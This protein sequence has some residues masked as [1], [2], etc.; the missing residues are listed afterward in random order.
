MKILIADDHALFR[1]YLSKYILTLKPESVILQLSDLSQ[2]FKL[3]EK[4]KID[5]FVFDLD[6]AEID[7]LKVIEK[8]KTISENTQIVVLSL[9]EDI[10]QI[11]KIISS[12]IMGY[13]P[14]ST[15]L[16]LLKNAFFQILNV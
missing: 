14:R 6:M 12:G 2:S 5:L 15:D 13:I 16:D 4:E 9:T 11:K 3:L 8:I 1:D 7:A 10:H